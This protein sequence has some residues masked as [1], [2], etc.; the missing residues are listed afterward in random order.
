MMWTSAVAP[1]CLPSL[2]TARA[3]EVLHLLKEKEG[4]SLLSASLLGLV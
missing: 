3:A 2:S 1:R 4:R